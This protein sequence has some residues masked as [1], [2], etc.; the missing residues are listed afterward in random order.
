MG[1]APPAGDHGRGRRVAGHPRP[2]R[3]LGPRRRALS[4][5]L[6]LGA[7]R[8]AA[9]GAR[10]ESSRRC[11]GAY[12]ASVEPRRDPGPAQASGPTGEQMAHLSARG[13]RVVVGE[14]AAVEVSDGRLSGVRLRSGEVVPRRALVAPRVAARHALL[15]PLDVAVTEHHLGIGCQVE[16]DTTGRTA[17]PGGWAAGN[18]AD[19]N[20]GIMQAASSGVVAAVAINAALNAQ[21]T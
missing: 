9:R 15:D 8:P 5:L 11:P 10:Y 14:V 2:A 16:A 6:R 17:A 19:V 21:H 13:I 4:V 3:T 12:V 1:C 7:P 18:V 20:A